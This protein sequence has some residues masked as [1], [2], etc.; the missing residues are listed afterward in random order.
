MNQ[1]TRIIERLAIRKNRG[2]SIPADLEERKLGMLSGCQSITS[3]QDQYCLGPPWY[4]IPANHNWYR[5][6]C[7]AS[8][9]VETLG[10]LQ[11]KYPSPLQN[12]NQYIDFLNHEE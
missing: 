12:S 4:A 3:Q 2:N 7:V 8:I 1:K 9:I 6:L 10:S 5:N 11:L